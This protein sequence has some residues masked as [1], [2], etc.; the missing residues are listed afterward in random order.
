MNYIFLFTDASEQSKGVCHGPYCDSCLSVFL[1][2]GE[3]AVHYYC[4]H[5]YHRG[6]ARNLL[7]FFGFKDD[8]TTMGWCP[9]CLSKDDNQITRMLQNPKLKAGRAHPGRESKTFDP[10]SFIAQ[11][12]PTCPNLQRDEGQNGKRNQMARLGKLAN[13][14]KIRKSK[15]TKEENF[16]KQFKLSE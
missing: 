8:Q 16:Q 7:K 2:H 9:R 15:K 3:P 6:C 5:I 10:N 11:T 1:E 14:D 4:R 13:F 12:G